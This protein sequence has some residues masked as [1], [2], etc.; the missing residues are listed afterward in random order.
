MRPEN[1]TSVKNTFPKALCIEKIA[2]HLPEKVVTND[3]LSRENP[4]WNIP[5]AFKSTGVHQRYIASCDE[6]AFDLAVHASRKLFNDEGSR[7]DIDALIFCTQSPDYILPSNAFLLHKALKLPETCMAFDYNLSCSGYV[8]GLAI[9]QG[10]I[11]AGLAKNILL[12]TSDTYSKWIHPQDRSARLLFGDGAAVSLLSSTAGQLRIVDILC[13]TAGDHYDKFIIPAGGVRKPR[14]MET[15]ITT[16]DASGNVRSACHINMN[17]ME[18][19]SFVNSMIPRHVR[20]ILERN[21][22]RTSDIKL[23]IFH[24]AS[25]TVLDSLTR[26]LSLRE[27]VV[28]VNIGNIG[29][30]VSSSIPI[31][32]KE[33]IGGHRLEQGDKILLCGFGVGLSWGSALIEV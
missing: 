33:V 18:I 19:L 24:Q 12:V 6:T 23:Y 5:K 3:D 32:L 11:S 21:R 4:S 13:G 8:Y 30:T 7:P 29:N 17:G 1:L 9:S 15:E 31:A 28:F 22:L 16:I 2:F 20:Q 25:R 10:L 27:E 26:L 14:S